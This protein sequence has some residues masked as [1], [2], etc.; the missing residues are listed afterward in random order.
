[1]A[2]IRGCEPTVKNIQIF[3]ISE[4]GSNMHP[5]IWN[6]GVDLWVKANKRAR[7][8]VDNSCIAPDLVLLI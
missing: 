8:D 2:V 5:I 6:I 1:M 4:N 7:C 3:K